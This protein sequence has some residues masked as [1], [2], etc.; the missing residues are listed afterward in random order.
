MADKQAIT[1]LLNRAGVA[2]DTPDLDFLLNMFVDDGVFELVI[3]GNDPM[4]FEGR[5]TINGLFEGSLEDQDDQRRH[6]VTNIFF[7]NETE[8][9]A[10]TVSYLTLIT[11][12]DGA[13]TVI[14]SGVYT[15]DVVLVDGEW[16][17]KKRHLLLD[18]PY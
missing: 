4:I 18:L 6:V 13:L 2:Y 10:T 12:K 1:E 17:L 15:D 14:S 16:K 3:T 5:E 7:Q 8:T 9:S 11:V